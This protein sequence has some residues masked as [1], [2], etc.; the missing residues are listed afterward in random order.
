MA[1]EWR[2][3]VLVTIKKTAP[4]KEKKPGEG[5]GMWIAARVRPDGTLFK[6]TIRSG[7]YYQNKVT[8]LMEI[9]K[10]GLD[11]YDCMDLTKPSK[12]KTVAVKSCAC[13]AE[14]MPTVWS[15]V[16]AMLDPKHP[17]E[18]P[19]ADATPPAQ[20]EKIEEDPFS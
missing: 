9:P 4:E 20:E 18:L 14:K 16:V 8:G 15:D 2:D 6:V 12:Q 3:V 19:A 17:P 13:G 10:D 5:Y 1:G 7:R 11:Y